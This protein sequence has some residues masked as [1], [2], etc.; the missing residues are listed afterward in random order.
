MA[1]AGRQLVRGQCER[2]LRGFAGRK[3]WVTV[4]LLV[5]ALAAGCRSTNSHTKIRLQGAGATFPA[6]FYKR[7]VVVYQ[8]AH[9]DVLIDYQSI[10]SGGGIRA[11]TDST[12]HFAASD[13]PMSKKELEA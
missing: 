1:E 9:P 3:A 2:A 5:F 7:A 6:P 11:I 8:D 10:G 12:V 13:A 4:C